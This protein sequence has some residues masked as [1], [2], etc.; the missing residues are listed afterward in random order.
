MRTGAGSA[1]KQSALWPRREQRSPRCGG[2]IRPA[3]RRRQHERERRL[4]GSPPGRDRRPRDAGAGRQPTSGRPTL[5]CSAREAAR[6]CIRTAGGS[7]T[8]RSPEQRRCLPPPR[9]TS[10]LKTA[11]GLPHHWPPDAHRRCGGDR[12][13]A[14]PLPVSTPTLPGA[15]VAVVERCPFFSGGLAAYDASAARAVPGV[16]RSHS[17]CRGPSRATPVGEPRRGCAR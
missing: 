13:R 11:G 16:T 7:T 4:G 1:S 10:P 15:L 5:G 6:Y 2:Q 14:R 12:H 9:S 8:A 17:Y 3:G